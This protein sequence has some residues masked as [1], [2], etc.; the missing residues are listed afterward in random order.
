MATQRQSPKRDK[1]RQGR[2]V[3]TGG[4]GEGEGEGKTRLINDKWK[5]GIFFWLRGKL[6][7]EKCRLAMQY[8]SQWAI[9]E[10]VAARQK[11]LDSPTIIQ[12]IGSLVF[13][14][15]LVCGGGQFSDFK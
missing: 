6:V 10:L 15:S 13:S 8:G 11:K 4:Q 2:N 7:K 3:Q 5:M 14:S 12:E 1:T 9:T